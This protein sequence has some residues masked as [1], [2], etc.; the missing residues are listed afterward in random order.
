MNF[1]YNWIKIGQSLNQYLLIKTSSNFSDTHPR[2]PS[3]NNYCI[4]FDTIIIYKYV[5]YVK[6]YVGFV[7]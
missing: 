4:Y 3:L 6:I 1:P 2:E 7:A 5:N